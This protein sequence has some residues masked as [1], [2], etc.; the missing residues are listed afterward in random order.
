ME[1]IASRTVAILPAA[2]ASQRFGSKASKLL[3]NV[4]GLSVLKRS[5]SAI[6]AN[7]EVTDLILLCPKSQLADFQAELESLDS[8]NIHYVKGGDTRQAS[9]KAGLD[10]LVSLDY[11]LACTYVLV[12]DTARCLVTEDI[13]LRAL[14][15]VK[16]Y[17]AITVAI[18]VADT[19]ANVKDGKFETIVDRVDTWR[20]QTPQIFR[21]DLLYKAHSESTTDATDD[22]SLVAQFHP[23]QIV[24]G[25]ETNLKL[26][27]PEDLQLFERLV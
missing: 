4:K 19:L 11:D 22:A 13:L 17:Q 12:H 8:K 14:D 27:R 3:T 6:S 21:G 9:V 10:Y 23:V 15:A 20:V 5:V 1:A 25:S 7:P 2:G 24:L 16:D 26:T 18:P